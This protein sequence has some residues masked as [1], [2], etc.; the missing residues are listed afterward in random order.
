M[1]N[2][3]VKRIGINKNL[4]SALGLFLLMLLITRRVKPKQL[5]K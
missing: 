4:I 1:P 3:K 5:A 2:K